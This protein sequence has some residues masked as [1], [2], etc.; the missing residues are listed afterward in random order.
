[1]G[2]Q[3]TLLS[4]VEVPFR[5]VSHSDDGWEGGEEQE[6]E[7]AAMQRRGV[8]RGWGA[9]HGQGRGWGAGLLCR[10]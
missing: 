8:G 10:G 2:W 1:M 4:E 9:G 7:G 6:E 3:D 5:N